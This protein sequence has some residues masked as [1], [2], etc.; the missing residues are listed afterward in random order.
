M[1][2]QR[3]STSG[4]PTVSSAATWIA[5]GAELGWPELVLNQVGRKRC[6]GCKSLKPFLDF[7]KSKT[8]RLGLHNHCRRCQSKAKIKWY[9]S[10]RLSE[11][12]KARHYSK[13]EVVAD[14]RRRHY[15]TDTVF[16]LAVLLRNR[17]RRRG[18]KARRKQRAYETKRFHSDPQYKLGKCLRHRVRKALKG[19]SKSNSTLILLGCSLSELRIHLTAQFKPGMSWNNYGYRGWH[20]D[21]IRPC[22]KFD[23]SNSEEQRACFHYTNLQPLWRED[24]QS[25][26]VL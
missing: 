13:T 19:L 23:L 6:G 21:H 10:R 1:F 9:C 16:R 17:L 11:R 5:S 4:A 7:N 20:V 12:R 18:L 26:S 25:K 14:R 2:T 15:K 22:A 3:R 24:N 8:G